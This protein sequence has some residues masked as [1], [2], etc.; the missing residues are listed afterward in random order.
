MLRKA[1]NLVC[2]FAY[3]MVLVVGVTSTLFLVSPILPLIPFHS[4]RIIRLRRYYCDMLVGLYL[5][6]A[7]IALLYLGGTK[8]S[9]YSEDRGI[10]TDRAPLLLCNHRTR[11]DWMYAG[12]CYSRMLGSTSSLRFVLKDSLRAAPVF[13]WVMQIVMCIF[14][15]RN[16]DNRDS[17]LG[18]IRAVINYLLGSG[19]RPCLLLFPEGTDL[20]PEGVKKSQ[21]Y[22]VANKLEPL[23]YVMYPRSSG[24]VT[25]LN[26]MK[27]SGAAMHDITIGYED[28]TKGV[29]T[30][31]VNIFTGEFPKHIHL[32]VKRFEIDE[33]PGDTALA[34]RWIKGSFCRK[35]RLLKAF[36]ENDCVP[37]LEKMPTKGNPKE[38]YES[39]PPLVANP[40]TS[41]RSFFIVSA[42]NICLIYGFIYLS[43]VRWLFLALVVVCTVVK[44]AVNGFD[45]LELLLHGGMD[46][47]ANPSGVNMSE[48]SSESKK[49][50]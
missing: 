40:Q 12:W 50:K 32:C 34:N 30:S 1:S 5:E 11:V 38:Y 4:L 45:V 28:Y 47:L 15:S 3:L 31:E 21:A 35:E 6:Y 2:G 41:S 27:S 16:R 48:S 7:A 39:W 22:A 42:C 29:R 46:A 13:G 44:G 14:L 8:I 9:V 33:I 20:S 10:L 49:M 43:N 24:F 25:L 36:Y 19:A 37:P 23:N 17:Q 18:H 26:A